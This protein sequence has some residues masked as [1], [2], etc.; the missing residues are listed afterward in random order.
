LAHAL[1]PLIGPVPGA[2]VIRSDEIRKSLCGAEPLHR[3][4]S[5]GYAPGVSQRVYATVTERAEVVVRGGH[6]AI[7]DAVFARPSDREALERAAVAAG[8]PF[9]GLWL[10]AAESELVA[11][12]ERRVLDASDADA[13]VI[14]SQIAQGAGSIPWHRLDASSP[15]EDVLQKAI[16]V[17]GERL[18]GGTIRGESWAA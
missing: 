3:L 2:V 12:A 13:A 8:V 14:R 6:A 4:G 9:V 17:L 7:A 15:S 1:A 16:L 18:Q 11:R 5:E 10:D